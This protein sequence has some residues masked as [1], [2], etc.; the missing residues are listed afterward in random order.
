MLMLAAKV[1][2]LQRWSGSEGPWGCRMHCEE[3]VGGWIW[4][5]GEDGW[6]AGFHLSTVEAGNHGDSLRRLSALPF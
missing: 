2:R 3:L 1:R 4:A 5:A 6:S